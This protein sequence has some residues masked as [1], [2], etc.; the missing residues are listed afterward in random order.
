MT[1][2]K[3]LHDEIK[4]TEIKCSLCGQQVN[5]SDL[6]T[7]EA[8]C[9]NQDLNEVDYSIFMCIMQSNS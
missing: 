7:P 6:A 4:L 3:D 1:C 5:Q 2:N 8:S 9:G